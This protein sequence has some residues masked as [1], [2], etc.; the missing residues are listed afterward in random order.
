[1]CP[2]SKETGHITTTPG[3]RVL[4]KEISTLSADKGKNLRYNRSHFKKYDRGYM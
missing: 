4:K 1:M 2:G 3:R